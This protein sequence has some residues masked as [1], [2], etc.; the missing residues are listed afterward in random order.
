METACLALILH[1]HRYGWHQKEGRKSRSCQ[2]KLPDRCPSLSAH[3]CEDIYLVWGSQKMKSWCFR[4]SLVQHQDGGGALLNRQV[5]LASTNVWK[6]TQRPVGGKTKL[7][8]PPTLNPTLCAEELIDAH[9]F[10][11]RRAPVFSPG[12]GLWTAF[13]PVITM[14]R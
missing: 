2:R 8:K 3:E 10:S 1:R 9:S 13:S 11:W 14:Q 6:P 12:G 4:Q 5:T 7:K